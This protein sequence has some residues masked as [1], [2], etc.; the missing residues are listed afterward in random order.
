MKLGHVA[1][2]L[3]GSLVLAVTAAVPSSSSPLSPSVPGGSAPGT[4]AAPP[5]TGLARFAEAFARSQAAPEAAPPG[6]NDWTCRPSAAHPRPVVLIHGT[7]ANAHANWSGL[8]PV[9]EKAGHCVFALNFGAPDGDVF[10]GRGHIPESAK[11]VAAFVD[12]VLDATGA[13]R[14]DLVGHSQGGG[15]LPRWYLKF[16]GGAAKTHRLVGIAPSNHGTTAYGMASLAKSL[17]VLDTAAQ[18]AGRAAKDQTIGSDVNARLDADGD[19]VP[20]VRHTTVVTRTD[21]VVTPY[22]QQYLVPGPDAPVE[23]I[24][25]QDHCP[26]DL[27]AHLGIAYSP[28]VYRLV[29]NALDPAHARPVGCFG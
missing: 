17:R 26:A 5:H 24:T 22:R 14:V 28:V 7:W 21:E 10:K 1:A 20:G 25:L 11:E 12:E 29:L 19:T 27:S 16:E 8:S 6:A 23:N 3:A 15:L 18:M 9:L 2:A 4:T 13:A